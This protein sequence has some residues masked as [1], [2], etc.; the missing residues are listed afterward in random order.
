MADAK[1][2]QNTPEVEHRLATVGK[3]DAQAEVREDLTKA[4]DEV[5][6]EMEARLDR[7]MAVAAPV[8]K[9]TDGN[10]TAAIQT[11]T[12]Q[13]PVRDMSEAPK[14]NVLGDPPP[15]GA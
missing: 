4:H 8:Q 14:P 1:H 15:S 2:Q 12:G 9:V 3:N 5:R 10:E 13:I 11:L 6:E 7:A